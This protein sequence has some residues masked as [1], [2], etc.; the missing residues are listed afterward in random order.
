MYKLSKYIAASL[1]IVAFMGY[2]IVTGNT[3]DAVADSVSTK[4]NLSV[5]GQGK[6]SIKPDIATATVGV[7]TQAKTA[8]E[9]QS[10]NSNQ[11][12]NV[13]S[14]LKS[15][16]I[17]ADDIRTAGYDLSPRYEYPT[18]PKGTQR[19]T[20]I[21]Y[22]VTNQVQVTIRN[23]DNVGKTLDAVT[24]AGANLSG[25]IMFS[26]SEAKMETAYNDALTKALKNAKG[27]ADVLAKGL[28][29]TIGNPKEVVENGS[30]YPQPIYGRAMMDG[31]K[32]EG[33]TPI[34]AGQMDVSTSVNLK[35]EY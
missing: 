8:K 3:S 11:M 10:Q 18:N 31:M 16:G 4:S 21:G 9:A 32:L 29:V 17:S 6:V 22:A 23:I 14:A 27:K 34:S 30:S 20:L 7:T 24:N 5:S 1:L 25:N 35:Y 33:S 12:N 15:A 13:I 28:G 19:E 26:L 2:S